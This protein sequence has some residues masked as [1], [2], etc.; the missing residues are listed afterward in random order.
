LGQRSSLLDG[1]WGGAAAAVAVMF[2]CDGQAGE[3]P[4]ADDPPELPLASSVLLRDLV[5]Y[6]DRGTWMF[7]RAL[8]G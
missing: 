8:I 6:R 4:A 2:D 1:G 3:I 5:I 7:G